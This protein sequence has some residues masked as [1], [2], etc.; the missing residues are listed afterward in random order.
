MTMFPNSVGLDVSLTSIPSGSNYQA[1]IWIIFQCL[2]TSGSGIYRYKW[3]SATGV[4]IFES[5]AGLETSFR[6]K[7]TPSV[8]YDRVECVAED[9][10]LPLSGSASITISP[11]IG[12]YN[13]VNI[14]HVTD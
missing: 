3:S 10:V 9:T 14:L 5:T 13:T 11:V 6:I 4:L 7:S 12:D 2:A 1:G 8:C